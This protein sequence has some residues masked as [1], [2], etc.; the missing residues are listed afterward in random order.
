[1]K[2]LIT[3]LLGFT[4]SIQLLACDICGCAS[5]TN[6]LGVLPQF[7]QNIVGL[8]FNYTDMLHPNTNFNTNDKSSRV[9]EDRFYSTE[10]WLRFYP[11]ERLQVLTFVPYRMHQRLE[12]ERNTMIEGI[13]DIRVHANY[14]VLDFGDSITTDWKNLLLIGAGVT[15]PTGKYQQRDDTKLMLPA[16]FQIGQGTFNY[17]LSINHTIRWRTYGLNTSAQYTF[18][19]ENELSYNYGNQTSVASALFYWGETKTF[20][21]LPNVGLSYNHFEQDYQYDA[22]KLYTGGSLLQ[23]TAGVD[24][25]IKQYLINTFVQ[26]PV[27]QAI[28]SEQPN[29][30]LAFGVGF[31]MFFGGDSK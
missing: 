19:G 4:T 25:Y 30:Q 27:Y 1:M 24:F 7:N 13:G 6:Y 29:T 17:A 31:S 10:A 3:L 12:T 26:A 14:T 28:P 8:R 2:F 5:G 9:L 16:A 11:T 20:A 21:Y 18:R 23:L 22:L 15:L